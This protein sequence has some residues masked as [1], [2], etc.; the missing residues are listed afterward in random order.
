METTR[1]GFMKALGIGAAVAAAGCATPKTER[2]LIEEVM[3]DKACIEPYKTMSFV[4]DKGVLR[5]DD[6]PTYPLGEAR[7]L[8]FRR[9]FDLNAEAWE[10]VN[11][12]RADVHV[13]VFVEIEFLVQFE[14][15]SMIT[16]THRH[17]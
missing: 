12:T 2:E 5:L 13:D 15:G 8:H 10:P 3:E 7:F 16:A 9:P 14:D 4:T 1:R 11:V 17:P 6:C